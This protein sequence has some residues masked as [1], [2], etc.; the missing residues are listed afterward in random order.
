M[1]YIKINQNLGL[2]ILLI[3]N[4]F[5]IGFNPLY[6][7][8]VYG[9]RVPLHE[10]YEA[11][12]SCWNGDMLTVLLQDRLGGEVDGT[13]K[14]LQFNGMTGIRPKDSLE[15]ALTPE[16][17]SQL[18]I[19]YPVGVAYQQVKA[20][21][22]R[23]THQW[24]QH[25]NSTLWAGFPKPSPLPAA[26]PFTV[27]I[28]RATRGQTR[29]NPLFSK[30]PGGLQSVVTSFETKENKI[31]INT[32]LLDQ[33]NSISQSAKSSIYVAE[34]LMQFKSKTI[35][36][37][38]YNFYPTILVTK[39]FQDMALLYAPQVVPRYRESQIE[40]ASFYRKGYF[41][42]FVYADGSLLTGSFSA[43]S[44][45]AYTQFC[46]V[47]SATGAMIG[48]GLCTP[49]RNDSLI[50]LSVHV[51]SPNYAEGVM[52]N[53]AIDSFYPFYDPD[54]L[55]CFMGYQQKVP[56]QKQFSIRTLSLQ[57]GSGDV[58]I[59]LERNFQDLVGASYAGYV[60]VYRI[61][62]TGA[63]RWSVLVPKRQLTIPER[64]DFAS[65]IMYEEL[66][67][68][69]L[70]YNDQEGNLDPAVRSGKEG[71]MSLVIPRHQGGCVVRATISRDGIMQQEVVFSSAEVQ[72]NR[73]MLYT[74][75]GIL[76]EKPG[77][78]WVLLRDRTPSVGGVQIAKISV[79][80]EAIQQ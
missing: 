76:A 16:P 63:L 50:G 43:P 54:H 75:A 56:L 38:N 20:Q 6:A 4:I 44:G 58:V 3:A 19:S 26:Q 17:G 31:F 40:P 7:Q 25:W 73:A 67:D 42:R 57:D 24:E 69:V 74:A 62:A 60:R 41:R 77:E 10:R 71:A 27:P 9:K 32:L 8:L 30:I 70:L 51:F 13:I 49:I 37:P 61:S 28:S 45:M 14:Y 36:V 35:N 23:A 15:L 33:E 55:H 78:K 72:K 29:I 66:G 11:V 46:L 1:L 5:C 12:G 21:K 47:P 2:S 34:K 68:I 64:V 39:G 52:E 53:V 79:R 22:N 18:W 59:T 65:F 48:A 80:T